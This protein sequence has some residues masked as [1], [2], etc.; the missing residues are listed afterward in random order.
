MARPAGAHMRVCRAEQLLGNLDAEGDERLRHF[1]ARATAL[2]EHAAGCEHAL[3]QSSDPR[4]VDAGAPARHTIKP[5]ADGAAR[6]APLDLGHPGFFPGE[7]A[8]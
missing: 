6:L 5:H 3:K 4:R 2:V 8:D 1:L 7:L